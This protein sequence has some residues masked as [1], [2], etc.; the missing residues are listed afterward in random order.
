MIVVQAVIWEGATDASPARV[1]TD[2]IG[3]AQRSI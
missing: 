2:G 1:V 3:R